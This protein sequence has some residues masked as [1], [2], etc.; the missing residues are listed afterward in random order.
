MKAYINSN[1][2][3]CGFCINIC[4]D[5]FFENQNGTARASHELI[6]LD[7]YA[8][9]IEAKTSCPAVAIETMK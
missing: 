9:V 3:G 2:T 6:P 5:I 7:A 8:M 1:C 4:P